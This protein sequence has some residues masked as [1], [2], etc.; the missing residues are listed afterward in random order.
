M[1]DMEKMEIKKETDLQKYFDFDLLISSI[2]ICMNPQTK[3]IVMHFRNLFSDW[4]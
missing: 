3:R 4:P 2:E 1:E